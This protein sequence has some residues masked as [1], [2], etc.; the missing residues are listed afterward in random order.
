MQLIVVKRRRT[1]TW[2]DNSIQMEGW[3]TDCKVDKNQ[4]FGGMEERSVQTGEPDVK[5]L[6]ERTIDRRIAK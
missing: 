1:V 2:N 3:H 5:S 4:L 6:K